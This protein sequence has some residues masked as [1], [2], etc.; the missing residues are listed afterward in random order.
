MQLVNG[1]K[2][3]QKMVGFEIYLITS[4]WNL[5]GRIIM[6]DT[7]LLSEIMDTTHAAQREVFQENPKDDWA[8][9]RNEPNEKGRMKRFSQVNS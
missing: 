1:R 4:R 7:K 9:E 3:S 8:N 6:F 2:A 5:P